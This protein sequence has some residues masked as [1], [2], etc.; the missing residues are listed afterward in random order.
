MAT[1]IYA[2]DTDFANHLGA[3]I[4]ENLG[5][6]EL[7]P[8][9]L[10]AAEKYI[11]PWL[12]QSQWDALVTAVAGTPSANETALLP[13]VQRPLA[14]FTMHE[15]K[16]VGEIMVSNV[17]FMRQET[18]TQKTAYKNQVNNYTRYARETGY[19]ALE[20]MLSFLEAA[21]PGTYTAWENSEENA[22]NREAFINTARQ[23]QLVYSTS[24][25][26]YVM[27][28][29]RGLMLDIEEFAI[30]PLI[31]E[32]FF[33]ELKTAINDKSTTTEQQ[34]VIKKIQK[35]VAAFTVEE[36]IRRTIVKN[37]GEAIV[38]VESLEPQSNF[39]EGPASSERLRLALRHN[40]EWGNRHI[41]AIKDFLNDNRADYPTYKTWIEAIEEA[42][43]EEAQATIA[44]RYSDNCPS[45]TA[46][47]ANNKNSVIRL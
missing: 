29:M 33:S 37:T 42:A 43:E 21:T 25:S 24:I 30:V 41:S 2:T 26:R 23:F 32:P 45:S 1:Y 11:I 28:T 18:D 46:S 4:S 35:A 38:V 5:L 20:A 15:Y 16:N 12:G 14:W 40:D 7:G 10:A 31:G 47:P 17:G 3:A 13:Y 27:E 44:T 8:T 36:G 19:Q 34:K 9:I 39:K 6:E 22:R